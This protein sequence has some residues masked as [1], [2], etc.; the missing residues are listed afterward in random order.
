[1][2][3][4]ASRHKSALRR[5]RVAAPCS[6]N[7][8]AA[9]NISRERDAESRMRPTKARVRAR[10]VR[11][12]RGSLRVGGQVGRAGRFV[13]A[14]PM[15]YLSMPIVETARGPGAVQLF[16]HERTHF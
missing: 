12:A 5:T 16:R 4:Y 13:A 6:K 9:I 2:P 11:L 8:S 15:A 7:L 3:R 14:P 10:L 1:M